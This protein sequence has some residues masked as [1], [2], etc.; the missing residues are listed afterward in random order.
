[1]AIPDVAQLVKGGLL[2]FEPVRLPA[3]PDLRIPVYKSLFIFMIA[4]TP[5]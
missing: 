4:S 3:T 2:E 1:M 5:A